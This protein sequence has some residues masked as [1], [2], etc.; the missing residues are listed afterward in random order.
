M[1][2]LFPDIIVICDSRL[3]VGH[4]DYD[5][6]ALTVIYNNLQDVKEQ[7]PREELKF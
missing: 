4:Q 7:R 6:A 2:R 5:P 3:V 1:Y